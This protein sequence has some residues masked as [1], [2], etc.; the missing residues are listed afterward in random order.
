VRGSN[1]F[2]IDSKPPAQS[3]VRRGFTLIELLVV[4]GLI[5]FLASMLTYAL[6]GAQADARVART[7]GTITKLNDVI[8]AQWEEYR[9]RPVDMRRESFRLAGQSIAL[10]P[11]EFP[12]SMGAREQ[13]YFRMLILR[14]TMRMEAPD[15]ACD[16]LF[17][18]AFYSVY[19]DPPPSLSRMRGGAYLAQ[20][21]Y[22]KTF[23]AL[24]QALYQ[25]IDNS[26]NADVLNAKSQFPLAPPSSIG[27][28]GV[29]I[30]TGA[31]PALFTGDSLAG[32]RKWNEIV[33]SGELLYLIVANSQYAGSPALE[34]FRA[35]E[36]GD[37]DEDGLLE[38]ID[39]W[40]NAIHWIRWPAGYP[41]D[42][43]RYSGT[44][45]M[46]P[47]QTDW[48]FVSTSVPDQLKPRTIVPLIMSAGADESFGVTQGFKDA[49]SGSEIPIIYAR[50]RQSG[51]S[52]RVTID[53]FFCWDYA[54]GA[55]G[56]SAL[57][58]SPA[59]Y[60]NNVNSLPWG[61]LVNQLGSIP[62]SLPDPQYPD[63]VQRRGAP[64]SHT[65]NIT[66]HDIILG[67]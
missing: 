15:S 51:N 14:D 12:A 7:R 49:N 48:R 67:L 8:L 3:D 63:D 64:V 6:L 55:N 27:V 24:Y 9:Y 20:R 37:P 2:G 31:A 52:N 11:G 41:S 34:N 65:D 54:Q 1:V 26:D 58:P 42:L 29:Y 38:F 25:A 16:L 23:G 30:G 10:P 60:P 33:S 5:G 44:D 62:E 22:P 35:S 19:D 61:N 53:P 13:A 66:N 39:A 17:G 46:D 32:A 57:P 45:A 21:A 59:N 50:M 47:L 4:M 40:G 28:D 36:I 43:N 18:P 56:Q